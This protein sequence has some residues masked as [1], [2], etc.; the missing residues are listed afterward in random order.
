M[1]HIIIWMKYK[2]FMVKMVNN[3]G[4]CAHDPLL[5]HVVNACY[6]VNICF[7]NLPKIC[8]LKKKILKNMSLYN[9]K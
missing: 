4:K 6:Y 5:N 7:E 9:V 2:H 8:H 3:V 1:V